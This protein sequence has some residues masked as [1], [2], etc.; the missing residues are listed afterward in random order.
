MPLYVIGHTN[1]DTDAICSAIGYAALL[2][3]TTHPDAEPACCGTINTRTQFVLDR[4]GIKAP[5][6]LMDVAPTAATLCRRNVLYARGNEPFLEVYR[7]MQQHRL[8]AIPVLDS[9]NRVLGML[10]ILNLLQIVLPRQEDIGESRIVETSLGR[11][12][13]VLGGVYQNDVDHN[14]DQTLVMMI[15]AMSAE[16]FTERLHKYQADQIV[17]LSGDR[18]TIHLPAIEYGVR[19]IIVT[20]GHRMGEDLV[21]QARQRGVAV[22]SSPYDTAMTSMLIKGAQLITRAVESEYLSF[23]EQAELGQIRDAVKQ[24]SQDLFPVLDDEGRLAGV[25]SKSDLVNPTQARL[26]LVDHNEYSQAVPG[27]RD[28]D[29]VE[30]LDHHRLGGGMV[31]REPMRFINEPVGSTSTIVARMFRERAIIPE[32]PVALCLA[33]G[34]VSDTLNLTSPTTTDVDRDILA[35]LELHACVEIDSYAREF[36]AAG[37]VLASTP[38]DEVIVSDCKHYT[39][40]GRAI[41][42]SQVEELGMARFWERKEEL[43]ASLEAYRAASELDFSC[44][45]I[46]D[47]TMHCSHLLVT[48]EPRIINAIRYPREE[49][50]LFELKGVVSRKKQL[51]PHLINI[52]ADLDESG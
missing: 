27:A 20:G 50:H 29:V 17:L 33:S 36:F 22:I 43:L 40:S 3:Q 15:G 45:L 49:P 13:N 25:F 18:P 4:A 41:S 46:T 35:W 30:V 19:C 2:R 7:R 32:R 28:A 5:Q 14:L 48:G 26:V 42:A 34:I 37:S 8:K 51:L 10:P 12:R 21:E 6:L 9:E 11:I 39:E 44:L 31:S 24:T 23:P 52:L 38:A 16:K 47:I 1:P